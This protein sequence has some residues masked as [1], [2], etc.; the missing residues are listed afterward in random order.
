VSTIVGLVITEIVVVV[1]QSIS[2]VVQSTAGA[3]VYIDCRMRYEGLDQDLMAT[4]E[5]RAA[6]LDDGTDPFR[7]DQARAV[8]QASAGSGRDPVS[9]AARAGSGYPA[10]DTPGRSTARGTTAPGLPGRAALRRSGRP[11]V[12]AQGQP[13]V[14]RGSGRSPGT[15]RRPHP[16]PRSRPRSRPVGRP[17]PGEGWTAPG[18]DR[19]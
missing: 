12:R 13:A 5:R 15:P 18:S 19:P 6:G 1:L 10:P 9:A 7:V 17:A 3:L 16:R 4:V 11:A 2:S 8:Q 14:P